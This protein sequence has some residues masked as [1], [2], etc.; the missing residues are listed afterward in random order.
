[1][2]LDSHPY[3]KLHFIVL[4]WGFT[5]V[6]GLLIHLPAIELVSYRTFIASLGLAVLM[7]IMG[8]KFF[9][10][11]R[12]LTKILLTGGLIAVHWILFFGAARVSN[13]SVS[14]IGLST[15]T[16][17]TALIEP[18]VRKRRISKMELFFGLIVIGGLYIIYS[19]EFDYGLGLLMS[20][21]SAMLAA[22]F[23]ILNHGF[24]RRHHAVTI[25]H[26]EMV[27]AFLTTLPFVYFLRQPD[28]QLFHLPTSSD[29]GYLLILALVCTVYANSESIQ[30][31]KKISAFASNL[32]INLEPVYGII[33]ALIFFG[34]SEQ[35]TGR[36]YLGGSILM[37][38][39]LIYPY[40]SRKL[41]VR[42][43]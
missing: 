12:E 20:L 42:E 30:V 2:M 3:L 17:W 26:Y 24:V 39:I 31:L 33:L 35:M 13:A 18:L 43:P 40:F 7:R 15:T 23:S 6:L 28:G 16:L 27:G 4:L 34:E 10:H 38:A 19:N 29:W 8:L 11:P 37:V 1:M 32:V 5:A 36:F 21:A 9:I 22:T 41:R 25:A 14:L